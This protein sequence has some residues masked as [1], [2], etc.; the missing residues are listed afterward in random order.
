MGRKIY[1]TESQVNEIINKLNEDNAPLQ[2]D[3]TSDV[4]A[5]GGNASAGMKKTKQRINQQGLSNKDTTITCDSDAIMECGKPIT[6]AQVKEAKLRKLR[7]S[8]VCYS[9]KQ[10]QDKLK[11]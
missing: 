4:A 7:E 11:K 10:F 8:S 2:V 5:A 1:M 6:K 3:A 9:K